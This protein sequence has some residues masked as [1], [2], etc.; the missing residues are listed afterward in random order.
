MGYILATPLKPPTPSFYKL[1]DGTILG[2]LI[3]INHVLPNSS[4]SGIERS[5]H[6]TSIYT[7][8][9]SMNRTSERI[10]Q[11]NQPTIVDQDIK[12][13]PLVEKFND[14]SVGTDIVVSVK[15]VVGQVMKTDAHNQVGE[16]I[17]RVN[18]QPVFKM[19][20]RK[21]DAVRKDE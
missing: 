12:C 4:G 2:A 9:P 16:P 20:N 8:V 18:V 10:Q 3:S 17:Y 14:Y 6:T 1:G 5:N 11:Q 19:V 15:T 13:T 7:F 21:T